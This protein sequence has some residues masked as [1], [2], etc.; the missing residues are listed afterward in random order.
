[1]GRMH[2]SLY[3]EIVPELESFNV[4]SL[5]S[6]VCSVHY[7]G[8]SLWV[9]SPGIRCFSED[10]AWPCNCHHVC[11]FL[12]KVPHVVIIIDKTVFE[13]LFL[14][15]LLRCLFYTLSVFVVGEKIICDSYAIGGGVKGGISGVDPPHPD[16]W[17]CSHLSPIL[18]VPG[19]VR[20]NFVPGD[21]FMIHW[22]FRVIHSC[23]QW[24]ACLV[25]QVPV[26]IHVCEIKVTGENTLVNNFLH[27]S[28]SRRLFLVCPHPLVDQ[29]KREGTY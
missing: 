29:W 3:P 14:Y 11:R 21:T 17:F 27:G 24:V 5:V 18:D 2:E 15:I 1:M 23:D 26:A 9:S 4:I 12:G 8:I 6:G 28:R 10:R 13:G 7:P 25:H 16:L 22:Y 20:M 19:P